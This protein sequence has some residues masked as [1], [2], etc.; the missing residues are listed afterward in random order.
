MMPALNLTSAGPI[1]YK[2]VHRLDRLSPFIPANLFDSKSLT[3]KTAEQTDW[4]Y[5]EPSRALPTISAGWAFLGNL[6]PNQPDFRT[7]A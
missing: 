4:P 5:K 7:A 3:L 1:T 2:R 6:M